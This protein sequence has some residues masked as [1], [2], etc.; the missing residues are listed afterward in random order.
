MEQKKRPVILVIDMDEGYVNALEIKIVQQYIDKAEIEFITDRT[1]LHQYLK[2]EHFITI[3]IVSEA[4]YSEEV[5]N[6]MPI[7]TFI[8]MDEMRN[9][10]MGEFV[11]GIFRYSSSQSILNTITAKVPE[12]IFE[13]E[14]EDA[15]V[16]DSE[17]ELVSDGDSNTAVPVLIPYPR[18][19]IF[20]QATVYACLIFYYS[21]FCIGIEAFVINTSHSFSSLTDLKYLPVYDTFL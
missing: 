19:Y 12:I 5:R 1:Y 9:E 8:L 4:M 20:Y 15:A 16:D 14:K 11:Y 13:D 2:E 10:K 21:L 17:R 18:K 7:Y 3:L 6:L